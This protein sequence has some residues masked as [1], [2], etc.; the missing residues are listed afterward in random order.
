MQEIVAY[1]GIVCTECPTYKATKKTIIRPGPRL[2]KNGVNNIN[3]ASR[4]KISI[5]AGV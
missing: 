3:I 5:A 2:P 1:C 4:L